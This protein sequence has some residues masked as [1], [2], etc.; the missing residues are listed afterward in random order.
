M[1][2]TDRSWVNLA[3][4]TGFVS[5][6][7]S[8]VRFYDVIWKRQS[9]RDAQLISS[10]QRLSQSGGARREALLGTALGRTYTFRGGCPPRVILLGPGPVGNAAIAAPGDA[11][12]Q[13]P[14]PSFFFYQD[15]PRNPHPLLGDHGSKALPSDSRKL[16]YRCHPDARLLFVSAHKSSL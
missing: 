7:S 2:K 4:L 12:I 15:W 13:R 8:T 3:K 16:I 10:C 5:K 9:R 14:P 6:G 1:L 11:S